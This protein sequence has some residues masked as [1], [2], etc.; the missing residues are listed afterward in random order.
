MG[1]R[2]ENGFLQLL[3]DMIGGGQVGIAHA[4]VD[5]VDAFG[6]RLGLDR[7]DMLE[8]VRGQTADA[9]EFFAHDFLWG[10]HGDLSWAATRSTAPNPIMGLI[11]AELWL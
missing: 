5:N 10:P 4:E 7:V 3:D 1:P 11:I 9:M 6:A 8:H 2:I